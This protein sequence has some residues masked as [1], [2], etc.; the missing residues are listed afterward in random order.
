M[1]HQSTVRLLLLVLALVL[2]GCTDPGLQLTDAEIEQNNRGVALMGQYKNEEAR[3][4]FAAL[5][6][7]Q[8]EW[9]DVRVNE[10][11]AT[12]NRQREGDERIALAMV[13]SLLVDHPDHVRARY[14]A[15]LM[16]FYLGD[17]ETAL[18]NFL[19]VAQAA[20]D[21]AH[22]AYF[23]AQVLAQ[24]ERTD[25]ALT[26]YQQAIALDPYLRSAYYGAALALRK[27]GRSDQ[28]R[29]MLAEYQ[30]FE[31]N[32]R[33]HLAEFRYT[34]KGRLAEALAVDSE[35]I[36]SQTAAPSGALFL[37]PVTLT[38]WA[39]EA[40]AGSLSLTT[41]DIN[42]DGRQDLFL[43]AAQGAS[44]VFLQ[45]DSGQFEAVLH[46]L[47]GHSNVQA[48]AWGVADISDRL[49]VY[50]CRDGANALLTE[51]DGDWAL[52]EGHADVA[53][54]GRCADAAWL[55]ADHD[56]DLDLYVVN[57]QGGNELYS[58]NFNGSFRR[59]SEASEP[60]LTGHGEGQQ[61][62]A[63]DLDGDRDVD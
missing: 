2:S 31:N 42:A 30:R 29:A 55:D 11:I 59:L 41:V 1:D 28:A 15:A 3:V 12:L 50:L 43:S 44:Q 26:Y 8:P 14:V 24:L 16:H 54:P 4:V 6:Q 23:T 32:P 22:V 9:L 60:S 13:E 38:D 45:H 21:D 61:L 25:D 19:S 17:S 5:S 57:Q 27:L 35:S 10:A 46:P 34:R 56:G 48:A 40:P 36:A 58:N 39:I 20:P 63:I 18:P 37:A 47:T 53:N 33:A 49:A 62:L 7:A 52:A 51:R